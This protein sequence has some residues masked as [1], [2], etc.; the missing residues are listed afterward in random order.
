M[1]DDRAY[2]I[3]VTFEAESESFRARV[4]ELEIDVEADT[5]AEAL[6]KAE[7]EIEGRINGA[8]QNDEPVPEPADADVAG[9]TLELT[10][11]PI[12]LRDLGFFAQREGMSKEELAGQL[13]ARAVGMLIAPMERRPPRRQERSDEQPEEQRDGGRGRGRGRGKK[14]REGYRPDLD[15]KSN[16]LAYLRDQ[17][18]GGRRR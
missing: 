9:E 12:V 14:Q 17:E 6:E 13:L 1:A 10:V 15:D 16:W 5:R 7:S 4:P 2:R 11:A 8:A 18:K 3:L